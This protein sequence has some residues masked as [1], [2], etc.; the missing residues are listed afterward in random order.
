MSKK[1]YTTI[2]ISPQTRERLRS[3]QGNESADETVLKLVKIAEGI[4]SLTEGEG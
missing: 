2:G 1:S 4:S 3:V